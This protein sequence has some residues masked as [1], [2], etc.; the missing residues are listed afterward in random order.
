MVNIVLQNWPKR[1][2]RKN[3]IRSITN[4]SFL[5]RSSGIIFRIYCGHS[6]AIV[7]N[8]RG[9]KQSGRG[10][11][12][13]VIIQRRRRHVIEFLDENRRVPKNNIPVLYN[14]Y[15]TEGNVT[16][17][18]SPVRRIVKTNVPRDRCRRGKTKRV[19][20]ETLEILDG[21]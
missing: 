15:Y 16:G 7:L 19:G 13:G 9:S 11:G 2:L 12:N 18:P 5:A 10:G 4:D 1:V 8:G 3:K 20:L 21:T 17:R 6:R 14:G